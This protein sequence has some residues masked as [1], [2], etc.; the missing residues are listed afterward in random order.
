MGSLSIFD[1]K[2]FIDDYKSTIFVETGTYMGDGIGYAN[3]F[4]FQKLYSIEL[5]EEFYNKCKNKFIHENKINLINDNSINGLNIILNEIKNDDRVLFWLDAHLPN[6]YKDTYDND[7]VYNKKILIPLEEE[8]ILI[9]NKK[10]IKNDVLIIDDL[11]IYEK[12]DFVGGN[13]LDV[14]NTNIYT[15]IDFIHNLLG[16]TH[17]IIKD[18]RNE[19]YIICIPK[20]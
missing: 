20:K 14:I 19:G 7:Y 5:I 2:N 11:R 9:K 18:Y 10:D 8:I 13:W 17:D 3:K 6:F 1:L 16:K 15:G 12:G 4:N